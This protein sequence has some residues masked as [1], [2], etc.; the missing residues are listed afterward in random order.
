MGQVVQ[1]EHVHGQ[2]SGGPTPPAGAENLFLPSRPTPPTHRTPSRHPPHQHRVW[3]KIPLQSKRWMQGEACLELRRKGRA[4]LPPSS[5][6]PPC[7]I[8]LPPAAAGRARGRHRRCPR[9]AARCRTRGAATPFTHPP[10]LPAPPR[11]LGA[12]ARTPT[13]G[14]VTV[15]AAPA[16]PPRPGFR[17]GGSRRPR[18]GRGLPWRG[19]AAPC[20]CL[21]GI[22]R[23]LPSAA[24]PSRPPPVS[25]LAR[26]G[27]AAARREEEPPPPPGRAALVFTNSPGNAGRTAH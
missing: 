3:T 20:Y 10:R 21:P 13:S 11:F 5:R 6:P 17:G 14:R 24:A 22:P 1:K 2:T 12:P 25:A 26:P 7:L 19:A 9:W 23:L 18:W 16:G 8:P 4:W 27:A 15:S